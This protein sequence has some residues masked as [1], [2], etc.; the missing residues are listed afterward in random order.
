M[1]W[2]FSWTHAP[3]IAAGGGYGC[4]GWYAKLWLMLH[5]WPYMGQEELAAVTPVL[6][7]TC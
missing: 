4:S 3:A 5:L 7:T 6:I 2:A 1:I